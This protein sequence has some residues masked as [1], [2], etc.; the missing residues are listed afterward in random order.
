MTIRSSIPL[1]HT[2]PAHQ[3][4]GWCSHCPDRTVA[5]EL[6]A[7]QTRELVDVE[8]VARALDNS[9]PYPVE[10]DMRVYRFMAERLLEMFSTVTKNPDHAMWQPEE[11][12][13]ETVPAPQD[14]PTEEADR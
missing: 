3:A 12:Q 9:T 14:P 1:G 6:A 7:W 5:E 4:F 8:D 11:D 10:L 2:I 13:P